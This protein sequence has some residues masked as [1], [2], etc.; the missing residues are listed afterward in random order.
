MSPTPSR[1]S[2]P[3]SPRTS[4]ASSSPFPAA[5]SCSSSETAATIR[6][7][8]RRRSPLRTRRRR[9]TQHLLWRRVA[10]AVGVIALVA[11]ALGLAFSGS[12]ATLPEGVRIAGVDVGGLTPDAA[13]RDLEQRSRAL[14]ETPV[15]FTADG[16]AWGVKPSQIGLSVN[17]GSAVATALREGNGPVPVRGFLRTGARLFA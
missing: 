12:P 11:V 1:S 13:K 15:T 3:T 7:L 6:A 17:W 8:A 14:A 16:H 9:S 10:V 2:A 4:Q 5:S